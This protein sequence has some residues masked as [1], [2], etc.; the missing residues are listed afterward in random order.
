MT[1]TGETRKYH[2][3]DTMLCRVAPN[4]CVRLCVCRSISVLRS[5]AAGRVEGSSFLQQRDYVIIVFLILLQVL[6]NYVFK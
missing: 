1:L 6:I 5:R 2:G 3:S 4:M